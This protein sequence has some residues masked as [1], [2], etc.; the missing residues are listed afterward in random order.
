[1]DELSARRMLKP[2]ARCPKCGRPPALRL[3]GFARALYAHLPPDQS[4]LEYQ[5][6]R[7]GCRQ[8][9]KVDAGAFQRAA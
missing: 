9:F 5:C 8:V 4:V 6:N 2:D 1:M 7:E 3:D